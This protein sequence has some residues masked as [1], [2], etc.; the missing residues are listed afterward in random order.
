MIRRTFSDTEQSERAFI[1]SAVL[2]PKLIPRHAA[3]IQPQHFSDPKLGK[4]WS[5]VVD[6]HTADRPIDTVTMLETSK[7]IWG[8]DGASIIGELFTCVPHASHA[9][10]Y[11]KQVVDGFR[12]RNFK[13]IAQ[14]LQTRT[15]D[16]LESP[17][18]IDD[19]LRTQLDDQVGTSS[20][21]SV[22]AHDAGVHLLNTMDTDRA[23]ATIET[24]ITEVDRKVCGFAPGELIVL[25]GRPGNCKTAFAL[26]VAT[27]AAKAGQQTLFVSLEMT[28]DEL[29]TRV[30]CGD[31]EIDSRTLRSHALNQDDKQ[32]LFAANEQW[33]DV[34]FFV[35][36][37]SKLDIRQINAMARIQAESTG[38]TFMVI[39]Y[40]GLI[41]SGQSKLDRREQVAEWSRSL[42]VM[43][44][45]L[46][47]PILVLVQLNRETDRQ[48]EPK[49]SNLA[50]SGS[51]EQDADVVMFIH[52]TNPNENAFQLLVAKHRHADL[53]RHDMFLNVRSMKMQ[54]E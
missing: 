54:I 51:I 25:A 48:P 2:K 27:N 17:E 9:S 37:S 47:I 38:L 1:G 30:L 7:R 24:G 19:W 13:A 3:T 12:I 32:Q 6:F 26:Q 4:F 21:R 45:E 33:A 35:Q 41:A 53:S 29:M 15:D 40:I 28:S 31:C 52:R 49:L 34:P 5:A 50:E 46:G 22:S 23:Q 14:G 16:L 10:H 11:A 8:E 20:I 36:D 44:K 43:A 39:D 42:K 18:T